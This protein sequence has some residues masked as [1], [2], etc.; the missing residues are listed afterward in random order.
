MRQ[1]ERSRGVVLRRFKSGEADRILLIFTR[2][3]GTLKAVARSVRRTSSKLAGHLEP[4]QEAEISLAK[5]RGEF[6]T[7]TG[8]K[9]LSRRELGLT[10]LGFA[11]RAVE[12]TEA[13]LP[14]GEPHPEIY[15]RLSELLQ[16]LGEGAGVR[17]LLAYELGLFR[18]AGLL[19]VFD[20]CVVCGEPLTATLAFSAERGGVSH[21]SCLGAGEGAIPVSAET[22]E[23]LHSGPQLGEISEIGPVWDY[24]VTHTLKRALRSGRLAQEKPWPSTP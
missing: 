21:R 10:G 18:L 12:L 22:L 3:L 7:V 4:L 19:P 13:L 23:G 24:Y 6:W 17:E 2:D 14:E 8:A 20:R 16:G 15:D 5:G 9:L 11:A 1:N